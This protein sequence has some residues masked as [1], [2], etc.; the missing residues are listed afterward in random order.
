MHAIRLLQELTFSVWSYCQLDSIVKEVKSILPEGLQ[1]KHRRTDSTGS[2]TSSRSNPLR[3]D[4]V[5]QSNTQKARSQLLESH[6][7]KL[8]KQKMEIF[9]KVEHT[10]VRSQC[11]SLGE[12]HLSWRTLDNNALDFAGISNNYYRETLLEEFTRICPASDL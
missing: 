6:L 11:L 9:T 3:D 2:T 4:R 1:R 10:Q 7:A 12:L 5:L 8:F